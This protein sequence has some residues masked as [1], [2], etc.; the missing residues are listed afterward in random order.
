MHHVL[1]GL[2]LDVRF[3]RLEHDRPI[4]HETLERT[5]AG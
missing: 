4:I 1:D 3:F 2:P 5:V